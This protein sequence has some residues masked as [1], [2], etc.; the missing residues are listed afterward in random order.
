VET[1][2]A[3]LTRRLAGGLRPE[4]VGVY[5]MGSCAMGAHVPGV[6]D[7]DVWAVV[8]GPLGRERTASLARRVDHAALACPARGLELVVARFGA[9]GLPVVEMN[10]NDGP[11]MARHLSLDPGDEPA[12]WFVLDAAIG[13][14]HGRAL[15]GPPASDAFPVL[16]RSAQLAAVEAS[17]AWHA[18]H[19]PE[20]PNALLNALRGWRYAA[21]GVWGSKEDAAR[22][23][24]ARRPAWAPE[25]SAAMAARRPGRLDA[26]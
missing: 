11:R 22:W 15:A 17:L 13:R 9:D 20:A 5:L 21:E 2:L 14:E 23:A 16:P 25:V 4:L 7:L 24:V 8:R 18:E 26:M 1:Y 19:E 6:S 12:H 3:E 10:L